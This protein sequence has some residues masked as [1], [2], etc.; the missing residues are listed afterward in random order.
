MKAETF[1]SPVSCKI[2]GKTF[3]SF[4][5]LNGH[6]NAHLSHRAEGKT[7]EAHACDCPNSYR[8]RFDRE[9]D[10][11][12]CDRCAGYLDAHKYKV[13]SAG[14]VK[15]AETFDSGSSWFVPATAAVGFVLGFFGTKYMKK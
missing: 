7:F 12:T 5:G 3:D 2:C 13:P 8:Y 11:K 10:A 1:E 6:M 4:R 14:V 15:Y 9:L